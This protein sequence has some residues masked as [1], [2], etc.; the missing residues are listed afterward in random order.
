[1]A[2][3]EHEEAAA[4]YIRKSRKYTPKPLDGANGRRTAIVGAP[5][6]GVQASVNVKK[7][8]DG[9]I[10][11]WKSLVDSKKNNTFAPHF[12]AEGLGPVVTDA[13]YLI[14]II[15]LQTNESIRNRFHFDSRFV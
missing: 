15:I 4:M 14:I 6:N 1:M 13:G 5:A 2:H 11:T 10:N 8:G 3:A 12:V 9:Q 7:W